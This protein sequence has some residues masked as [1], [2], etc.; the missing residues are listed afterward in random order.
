MDEPDFKAPIVE[1]R[2]ASLPTFHLFKHFPLFR[3]AIFSLPPWL[4]IKASPETAVLTHLQVILGKQVQDV[5]TNPA[6][7]QDTTHP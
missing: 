7:L 4:A 6:S 3:K 5:T 1:A 2:D